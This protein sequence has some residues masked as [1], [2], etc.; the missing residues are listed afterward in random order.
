MILNYTWRNPCLLVTWWS[1]NTPLDSIN[2]ALH[3]LTHRSEW[4]NPPWT[5][6]IHNLPPQSFWPYNSSSLLL[7]LLW[8]PLFWI[9]PSPLSPKFHKYLHHAPLLTNFLLIPDTTYMWYPYTIR[10]ITK[11]QISFVPLE[12]F[13]NYVHI[14]D[15]NNRFGVGWKTLPNLNFKFKF[16][17]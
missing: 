9:I 3:H 17:T 7:E 11:K 5:F 2:Q 6:Q 1:K 14:L 16:Q 12:P 15:L 13:A 10:T 4:F 8:T